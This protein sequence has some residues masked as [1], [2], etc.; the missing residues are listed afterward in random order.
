MPVIQPLVRGVQDIR[1]SSL[2]MV[3]HGLTF[4]SPSF[5]GDG[6][7]AAPQATGKDPLNPDD[8]GRSGFIVVF[9]MPSDKEI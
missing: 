3:Q 7:T 8:C 9:N 1:S 6:G 4:M 2:A 5:G